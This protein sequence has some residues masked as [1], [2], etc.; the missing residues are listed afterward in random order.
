MRMHPIV[1][2][3]LHEGP[4]GIGLTGGMP[5]QFA[6]TAQ[7][8]IR[9]YVRAGG[10]FLQKHLDGF[11]AFLAFEGQNSGWLMHVCLLTGKCQ[12]PQ[13]R[14]FSG[15]GFVQNVGL[16]CYFRMRRFDVNPFE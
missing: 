13:R 9:L 2:I 10:D 15:S 12:T 7:A 16:V 4:N 6:A 5:V 11:S 1:V 8:L 14:R 3:G